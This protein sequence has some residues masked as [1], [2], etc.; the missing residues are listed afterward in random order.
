M[1]ALS[2]LGHATVNIDSMMERL[3]IDVGCR[4]TPRFGLLFSCAL[5]NCNR[6]TAHEA[7]TTW[8]SD[9]HVALAGPPKFCPNF[10]LLS[11][12][13]YDPGVGHR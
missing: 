11:E 4:V 7:C 1:S 12:L 6:C 5:R 3:G 2:H 10:D 9:E 8:L 13:F